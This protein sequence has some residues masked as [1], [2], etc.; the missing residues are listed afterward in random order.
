[1]TAPYSKERKIEILTYARDN[2]VVQASKYFNIPRATI[3]RWNKKLQI[4]NMQTSEYPMETRY[5]ILNYVVQNSIR[6][7]V[8][9]FGV[10]RGIIER[11]NKELKIYKSPQ[12]KF[13]HEN[14][15]EI[16]YYARDY[17]VAAASDKYDVHQATIVEWNNK[18]HVYEMQREYTVAEKKKIL[19]FARDNGVA[20]AEREFDVP[21]GTMLRWNLEYKIYVPKPVPNSIQYSMDAQIELLNRAKQYYDE[22]TRDTRSANQ[23]FIIM[24]SEYDVT[25]DQLRKWNKK[26]H[27]VP[28]RPHTRPNPTQAD[29][30]EAQIAL[31][32]SHGHIARAARRS[33]MTEDKIQKMKTNKQISFKRGKSKLATNPP[34]GRRKS[35]AISE[36]I[37]LLMSKNNRK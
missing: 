31:T 24:A 32:S 19:R 3:T 22:M 4:Y 35:R 1:M 37:Q 2:G 33:G 23:A 27:I 12:R 36:I 25:P 30:D 21:G 17:G 16:L 13:T 11:W 10:S 29:I 6:A 28:V 15:L 34:I 9:K 18:M 26:Y 7:A 14:R 5:E 20:A 8:K